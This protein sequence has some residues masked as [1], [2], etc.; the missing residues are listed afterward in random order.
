M[1]QQVL[2]WITQYGYIAIYLLLAFG[3][4]G[5]PVPDETL[6]TFSGYLIYSRHLSLPLTFA[7]AFAGS[8][9]GITISYQLGR[10]FGNK[11]LVRYGKYLHLSAERLERA[12]SWFERIGHWALTVGYF[13]PGVRHLTAYAAGITEVAPRQF[14]IFAYSG[15]IL[16]VTAFLSLGYLIGDRWESV[17]KN[18]ERYLLDLLI[19]LVIACAAYLVWRWLARRKQQ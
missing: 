16:W 13:I 9:T 18:V 2:G 3:I 8:A 17:E 5:L 6:L 14:A 10:I 4:V 1:E 11:L 12:H 19:A 7:A 15:A